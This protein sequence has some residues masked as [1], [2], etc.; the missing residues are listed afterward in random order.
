MKQFLIYSALFLSIGCTNPISSSDTTPETGDTVVESTGVSTMY[1]GVFAGDKRPDT[2]RIE[3]GKYRAF[4]YYMSFPNNP[5]FWEPRT[6]IKVNLDDGKVYFP[7]Y[8][9]DIKYRLVLF[10]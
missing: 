4:T 10:E 7:S 3:S 2:L 6:D 8:G 1:E 9:Y 5:G